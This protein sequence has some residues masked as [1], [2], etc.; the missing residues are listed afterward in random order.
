MK[1]DVT[2]RADI[3][4][5]LSSVAAFASESACAAQRFEVRWRPSISKRTARILGRGL[6]H[7]VQ[8]R[9]LIGQVTPLSGSR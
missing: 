5:P 6:Q 1:V 7:P 4:A 9:M 8:H 3:A 2:T